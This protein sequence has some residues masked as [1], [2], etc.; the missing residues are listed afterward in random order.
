MKT[1]AEL[2]AEFRRDLL[3]F[4]TSRNAELNITDDGKPYGM[5]SPVCRVEIEGLFDCENNEQISPYVEFDL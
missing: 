4:L 1:A 3:E 2:E 5:H